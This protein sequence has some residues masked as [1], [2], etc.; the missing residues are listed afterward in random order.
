MENILK[1]L[2][3][4]LGL[5]EKVKA[6]K[7]ELQTKYHKKRGLTRKYKFEDRKKD[8]DMVCIILAGYQE[9]VWDIVFKRIKAFVPE[10]VE[11]CLCSSG[12]YSEK[13][14]EIAKNNDWSYLST[15]RNNVSLIQ[16]VAINLYKKATYIYKLDEDIFVTK[17]YFETLMQAYKNIEQNGDYDVGIVAPMIPINGYSYLN[18]IRRFNLVEKYKELQRKVG[19][20][21]RLIHIT[22]RGSGNHTNPQVARFLW[23]QAPSID[24]MNNAVQKDEFGYEVCPIRYSIGAILFKRKLWDEME[25]FEVSKREGMGRDEQ[26][27]CAYCMLTSRP[28]LISKNTIVGHLAYGPQKKEMEKLYREHKE[29]FEIHNI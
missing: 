14:S 26:K 4:K 16:N 3:K 6:K 10:N 7:I 21:E 13:L 18:I 23:E 22:E 24:E 11:V 1:T 2:L 19:I 25:Y 17:G 9:I 20:D 29:I 27:I 8:K 12:K 15:K 5:F 28:I